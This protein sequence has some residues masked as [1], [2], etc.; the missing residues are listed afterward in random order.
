M[1]IR[2]QLIKFD[3]EILRYTSLF[4]DK[5]TT[6]LIVLYEMFSIL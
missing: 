3:D 5:S 1:T 2:N 4:L 6:V